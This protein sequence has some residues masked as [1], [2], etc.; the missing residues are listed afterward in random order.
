MIRSPAPA[1]ITRPDA[2]YPTYPPASSM[3][4]LSAADAEEDAAEDE[5]AVLPSIAEERNVTHRQI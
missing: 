3:L 5:A 2:H 1:L 4:Q